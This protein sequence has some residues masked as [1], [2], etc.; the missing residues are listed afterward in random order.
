MQLPA[1]PKNEKER[2]DALLVQGLLTGGSHPEFD[3]IVDLAAYICD[4][5]ISLISIVG[6]DKQRFIG[7]HGLPVDSTERSVSFCAHAINDIHEPLLVE[8]A[9]KD[10]RF[11]E[12]PLVVGDP[13][14][15]FYAGFPLATSDDY[16]LGTLCVIDNKPKT[17]NDRQKRGL[18]FLTKQIIRFFELRR[19]VKEAE[20]REI[21]LKQAV[22]GLEEYTA[23]VA[24][25]LKTSLRNIEISTELLKK[26]HEGN[27]DDVCQEYLDNI[28]TETSDSIRFINDMLKFSKS[29]YTFNES[30]ENVDMNKLI[31]GIC[32][33]LKIPRKFKVIVPTALP[34]VYTS[35]TAI[36]HVFENLI[37]N[38]VKYMDKAKPVIEIQYRS[39]KNAHS[40][41]VID[42]GCG[43]PKSRQ[44]SVFNLFDRIP[45]DNV[46]NE[47][48]SGVGLAIVKRLILLLGGRIKIKSKVGKGAKFIF[49]IPKDK[50]GKNDI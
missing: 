9:T 20:E 45:S 12:N 27:I 44:E 36:Q 32:K 8:D 14:I 50:E 35:R 46:D 18:N 42:N 4:T 43:I 25:D 26:R 16:A 13:N 23:T 37:Q 19:I 48:S 30:K 6:K 41:R 21:L 38:S 5:P 47:N 29:V 15:V 39:K 1:I 49:K 2:L 10:S 11:N 3:D 40:F 28:Q 33:K 34:V 7:N 17:L 24:H 22:S 31:K